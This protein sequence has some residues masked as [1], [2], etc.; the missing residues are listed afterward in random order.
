MMH[1]QNLH[2]HTVYCVGADMPVQMV[3]AA[4]EKGF[5]SIGFSGHSFMRYSD[6]LGSDDKTEDYK[7]E[8]LRLKK[9]YADRIKIYLGLEVDM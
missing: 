4:L 7:K 2:T 5:A 9:A 3:E 1:I 8:I 6:Y